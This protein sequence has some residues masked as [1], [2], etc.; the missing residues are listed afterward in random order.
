MSDTN[1]NK[2]KATLIK[3]SRQK[4]AENEE[5]AASAE[6]RKVVVVKKKNTPPVAA[7]AVVKK[8]TARVVVHHDSKKSE[9]ASTSEE[10][11]RIEAPAVSGP[12]SADAAPERQPSA[13]APADGAAAPPAAD[14]TPIRTGPRVVGRVGGYRSGPAPQ[15]RRP[16]GYQGNNPTDRRPSGGYQGSG[17]QG[18]SP[19]GSG[20]QGGSSQGSGYQGNSPQGSGYQGGSSQGSGYQ[21][22]SSQGS[23]YQ[24][25][26]SQG[27]GGYQ[28][29]RPAGTGYQGTRPRTPGQ[30]GGYQGQSS[31]YQGQ[32]SGYQGQ[33]PA[34]TGGYQGQRPAGTG[35]YQGQR[36]A[37]TGGY[38]G[39]RPAGSRPFSGPPRPGMGRPG[40][41]NT[42]PPGADKK[43]TAKRFVQKAKKP[44]YQKREES[45]EQKLQLQ[46]KKAAAPKA[47]PVPK[48]IDI[49]ESIS[50]SELARKMNLKPSELIGKLMSMGVMA[51]IN[52]QI[53]SDTA[54]LLAGEYACEVHIVSLYD[55][56][57]IEKAADNPADMTHR[58][59]IVTVMGHVDH[60]KT[61][62]LDAIRK[63]NVI[64]GEFGGITQH[65]G[66]Y[67]V[68]TGR[69][70][71]TFLDTPGHEAFAK[72]RARGSQITDIV[73]LVVAANDGVMPQTVEALDHAK[74][75][76]VPIIVA[77][78]KID[79]P[80]ANPDRVKT[81]LSELGLI[82]E[83]W[84][85]TTMFCE[86]SALQKLGIQELLDGILLTAEVL[87][88]TANHDCF[89][90]G[91]ILEARIDQGRGIVATVVVERGTLR[92]GDSFLAG[93]YPGK[94]RA[95]YDD[96]G[97]R[98]T[99][100]PPSTPVEVI[101]FEGMPNSG[102][103]FEVVEDDKTARS[104]SGK[105][106]EL[107]RF[108]EAK[109]VKKVNLENLYDT[110]SDGNLQTLRVIIKG[111]V[112]GSV[113]ALKASLEKLSTREIRLAVIR[114]AAGAINETDV[115]LA[116]ASDAIIIAFNVRPTPKAKALADQE[117]V[118]IRKYNVIYK[119]VEEVR[120]AMEGMLAP[121]VKEQDIGK[122]EVR[123]VFK[124]PKIGAIAGSYV[125][126]GLVKRNAFARVI[127]DSV[128]I[129]DGKILSLRR[130]KD[131][132]R[133]VAAGYECGIG[134]VD[135]NEMQ[136]GDIF[137][138]YEQIQV[139]RKLGE[140]LDGRDK[141]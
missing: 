87:E 130:F 140:A 31:G 67:Q 41:P 119:A 22:G 7:A 44:N 90:E 16:G 95:L 100:A 85:G 126:E 120:S 89:A 10:P 129:H 59:P 68:D 12:T 83:A 96:A 134:L 99:E 32:S 18:N 21:G 124:V 77:V 92:I 48:V 53:D 24:G 101:G 62:L 74:A 23:G 49:M 78:N 109:A 97:V 43:P 14:K 34:G 63:T 102:D 4:P 11:V 58:A 131:D 50:V 112:H 40:A 106:Q 80:E 54:I 25:G 76:G 38:Q 103:P 72:M 75:A 61:K 84:G 136:E 27:G 29:Q 117:K 47:N 114:A 73:I 123:S 122:A 56:T 88:L 46:R 36:P 1:E 93:C 52:Q 60:G 42:P 139:S 51:T 3:Q 133:E 82:P 104:F 125:T 69:G 98:I 107:K 13:V 39:Q 57:L 128:E 111:D 91:K 108:E 86:I 35:G 15:D 33:R 66:A 8:T 105:R 26:P 2:P 135:W 115:D 37:G 71:I 70:K 79:L 113:E 65:I 138:I 20:Y 94:V 6:K 64:A 19:Q 9:S 110:I 55:E 30:T 127:R 137:E 121:E 45:L 81:Q 141:A 116:S 5:A 132:A 28:G 118:D 17:Y